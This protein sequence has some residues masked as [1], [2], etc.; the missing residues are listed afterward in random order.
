MP[1][2][3]PMPG[4]SPQSDVGPPSDLCPQSDLCRLPEP[5]LY[6]LSRVIV[7]LGLRGYF[8]R[9]EIH[10]RRNAPAAGPVVYAANHPHSVTDALVL[11][12]GAGRMLHFIAHSG[13]FRPGWK[14]WFL[15]NSGA[16]PVYRP[17]EEAQAG[18][19]NQA[20]FAA[21]HRV[22]AAG[23]AIGIFPEGTSSEEKRVQQ[24]RTGTARMAFGAEA[25][26][27]WRLGVAVVPVGL[28]FESRRR[29][30]S[31][32]LVKFG[33]PIVLQDRRE[34]FEA[35]PEEAVR[36]LTADLQDALRR[37]VVNIDHAE[38]LDLVR[39][40]LKMYK[41]ELLGRPDLDIAGG[42]GFQREQ[43]VQRE[44]AR[45]LD[46]FHRNRPEVLWGL[47]RRMSRYNRK[48]RLLRLRDE[49][50]RQEDGPTVEGQVGRFALVGA[51]GLAPAVIGLVANLAPYKATG[52]LAGRLAPDRTKVHTYQF[53][54]GV[55]FFLSWY[56][57]VITLAA[58]R[59]G[60]WPA[61]I[62]GVLLPPLG[63]FARWYVGYLTGRRRRLRLAGLEILQGVRIQELRQQR[64]VL[65]QEMDAA[66]RVYLESLEET[67]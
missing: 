20:M 36:K 18:Q 62:L 7:R 4:S 54:L 32:V 14:A 55:G 30:R 11:G 64:R 35:D 46:H 45:A 38:Y 33:R 47:S 66:L 27:G 63:L 53:V 29:F 28:N 26:N 31:G 56:A 42:T 40:V 22:L 15:R 39:D 10:G 52:W 19:K 43:A 17:T 24:L 67:N 65:I 57:L 59:L 9:V 41:D 21:C 48:R 8:R 49:M 23:G 58:D 34:D 12:H 51:I 60:T 1:D 50:L 25:E 16:I 6:R 13:L 44:I 3:I 61:A 5:W 2:L 37:E